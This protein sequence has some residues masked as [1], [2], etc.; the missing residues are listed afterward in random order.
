MKLGRPRIGELSKFIAK[1][2]VAALLIALAG[3]FAVGTSPRLRRLLQAL[4]KY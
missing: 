2:P 4:L 3:G 1:R